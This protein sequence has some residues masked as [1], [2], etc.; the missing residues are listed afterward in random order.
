M[1]LSLT[2]Y[3]KSNL[4]LLMTFAIFEAHPASANPCLSLEGT[5]G[6][7][8]SLP[9]PA[10]VVKINGQTKVFDHAAVLLAKGKSYTAEIAD[11]VFVENA[12][13]VRDAFKN[14]L[15]EW[16]SFVAA[17]QR[18]VNIRSQGA[19]E[20]VLLMKP[21]EIKKLTKM[22]DI[23]IR[24][25]IKMTTEFGIK[26]YPVILSK[27]GFRVRP[28]LEPRVTIRPTAEDLDL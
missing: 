17:M 23:S 9:W 5:S 21:K 8:P 19:T 1:N 10:A 16:P 7:E 18:E 12:D 28:I 26:E 24:L 3:R 4:I 13:F 25:K 22:S 27:E 20:L 14:S 11:Q 15:S 6:K 2:F